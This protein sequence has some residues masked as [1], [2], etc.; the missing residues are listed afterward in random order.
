LVLAL[1]LTAAVAALGGLNLSKTQV[2]GHLGTT[3]NRK[4]PKNW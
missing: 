2:L 4:I 1:V 3:G